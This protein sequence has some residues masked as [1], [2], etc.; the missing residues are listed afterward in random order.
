VLIFMAVNARCRMHTTSA[1]KSWLRT[2][3]HAALTS[4]ASM[5]TQSTVQRP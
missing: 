3:H 2:T 1:W 4:L 5:P